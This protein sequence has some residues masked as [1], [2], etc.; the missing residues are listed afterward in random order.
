MGTTPGTSNI[1]STFKSIIYQLSKIFNVKLPQRR[2]DSRIDVSG[3]FFEYLLK[4]SAQYPKKKIVILLDSLDQLNTGDYDIEWIL[5]NLPA[6]IKMIY[7]TL[8]DHGKILN[9][10]KAI[11]TNNESQFL[12]VKML[13]KVNVVTILEDWLSKSKRSLSVEQWII[14]HD[15]FDR[16]KLFPL[17]VKLIYDIIVKWTSYHDPSV[18]FKKCT[19]IDSSIQYLFKIM[20]KN[21]GEML[22]SRAMFYMSTF[23]NG[24]SECELEDILSIDDDVLFEIFEYHIPP[25]N[26]YFKKLIFRRV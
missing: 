14:L 7:S 4:I 15:L 23:K 8:P 9:K 11:I 19:D 1:I 5:S 22:F 3:Y 26:K 16:A 12:E 17:Y 21:H 24:I 13:T 25:V 20:A 6:N 2:L 18:E 10:F